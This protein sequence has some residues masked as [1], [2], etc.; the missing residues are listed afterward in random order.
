QDRVVPC[1]VACHWLSRWYYQRVGGLAGHLQEVGRSAALDAFD[2][3]RG[4]ALVH[5]Q[6]TID[7]GQARI[8]L[9]EL[10]Q[11]RDKVLCGW[12]VFFL[13]G[14]RLDGIGVRRLIFEWQKHRAFVSEHVYVYSLV[15]RCRDDTERGRRVRR[16]IRRV[17]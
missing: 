4:A 3:V 1:L 12:M 14:R 16:F 7:P 15:E 17:H 6:A 8:S 13:D 5:A 10:Q 9:A 2:S 11:R